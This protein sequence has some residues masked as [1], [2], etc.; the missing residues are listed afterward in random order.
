MKSCCRNGCKNGEC[1]RYS[2]EWGYI[3]DECFEEMTRK[4]R[5]IEI[6]MCSKKGLSPQIDLY[7][8]YNNEFR[9]R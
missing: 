8:Y 5:S 1:S 3:C 6:F 7:D 9:R 4:G 2:P